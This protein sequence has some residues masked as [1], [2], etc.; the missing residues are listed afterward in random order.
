MTTL[1]SDYTSADFES[2]LDKIGSQ[3]KAAYDILESDNFRSW[4]DATWMNF[5]NT[6]GLIQEHEQILFSVLEAKV[7]LEAFAERIR[8]ID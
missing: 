5:T 1:P 4:V 8:D 2:D 6:D 3:L 7:R